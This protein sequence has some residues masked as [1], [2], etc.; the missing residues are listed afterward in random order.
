MRTNIPDVFSAGDVAS[1]PLSIQ[2]DKRVNIGHWQLAQ[3]HGNAE[4]QVKLG[5]ITKNRIL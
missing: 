5:I 1:F 3:A 4:T 2:A